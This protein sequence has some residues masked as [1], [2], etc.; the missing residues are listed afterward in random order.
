MLAIWCF[1]I[2][3]PFIVPV[4]W[5]VIIA[6]ATHPAY[7]RLE[8][9][10]GGR[11]KT[12]SAV[13]AIG[14]LALL[15]VP[16]FSLSGTLVDGAQELYESVHSGEL[17]VPPPPESVAGWPIIGE[18]LFEVWSKASQNL[19]EA[20]TPFSAQI[21]ALAS[22]VLA[23]A[24]GAGFAVLQWILSIIIAAV[25]LASQEQG[26]RAARAIATRIAGKRGSELTDL[27]GE[28]VRS[29]ATGVVGV[30]IIQALLAG[31]GMMLAGV[32]AAG[33]WTL[34]VLVLAVAQLPTLI[35]L[36]PIA[37]FVFTGDSTTVA[38]LFAIWSLFVG[39]SDTFLKPIFLGRGSSVPTVV[40]FLGAIGGMIW[41]GILGLFVGAVVL[42]LGYTLFTIWIDES[43]SAPETGRTDTA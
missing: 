43:E 5:G 11:R 37:V 14:A 21:R 42:T 32:P 2:I 30:A 35:V 31:L 23:T 34:L 39:I 13:F 20:L 38:V 8:G 15:L 6:V 36:G 18:S 7:A 4:L 28:T 17:Q 12:A 29:V 24:A 33:L 10:C 25:L 26:V 16:T 27:A 3:K 1:Q 9:M 22:S 40:I 19:S 41:A